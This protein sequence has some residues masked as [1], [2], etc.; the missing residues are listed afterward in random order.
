MKKVLI[1]IAILTAMAF[2]YIAQLEAAPAGPIQGHVVSLNAVVA[3]GDGKV[4]KA[5]AES[6]Q[7]GGAPIAFMSGGSVY[8]VYNAD[9]SFAGSQLAKYASIGTVGIYGSAKTVKG[10]KVIMSKKIVSMD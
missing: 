5:Q 4:A 8:L 6:L 3:G 9:G 2:A 7:S 1:T 10:V